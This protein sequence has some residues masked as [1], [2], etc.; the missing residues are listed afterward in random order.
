MSS[1]VVTKYDGTGV[2]SRKNFI[3][4]TRAGWRIILA[5]QTCHL[6]L[7]HTQ[8]DYLEKLVDRLS[9]LALRVLLHYLAKWDHKN[10]SYSNNDE[11]VLRE[12]DRQRW[13]QYYQKRAIHILRQMHDAMIVDG[14]TPISPTDASNAV[15]EPLEVEEFLLMLKLTFLPNSTTCME[16][17]KCFSALPHESVL[18]LA[19]KFDDVAFPLLHSRVMTTRGLALLLRRHLPIHIGKST[20]TAMLLEDERRMTGGSPE[21]NVGEMLQ[22]ATVKETFLLEI[23]KELR[24]VGQTL[25][26]RPT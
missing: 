2:T 6:S 17:M 3:T 12:M 5:D 21:V 22:M 8:Y 10:L 4:E 15:L 14:E 18:Q 11:A 16:E 23:E 1:V 19:E 25:E 13:R 20:I 9:G 24:S 26:E 7:G